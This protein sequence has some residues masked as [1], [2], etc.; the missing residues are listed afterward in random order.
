MMSN[1]SLK[2]LMFFLLIKSPPEGI[3]DVEKE[4]DFC[5][6]LTQIQFRMKRCILFILLVV[7]S[8]SAHAQISIGARV[9]GSMN[10]F[11]FPEMFKEIWT[12]SPKFS[13]LGGLA[14]EIPIG[15]RF[16]LQTEVIYAKRGS[17][18]G[19]F[20]KATEIFDNNEV[21][22][23]WKTDL[24]YLDIPLLF[25]YKFRGRPVGGHLLA[26]LNFGTGLG[27]KEN[28]GLEN[29]DGESFPIEQEI[30]YKDRMDLKQ[31]D[32]VLFGKNSRNDY[33]QGNSGLIFGAGLSLDTEVLK[34]NLD[35]RYF[36][37]TNSIFN[38][39]EDNKYSWADIYDSNAGFDIW[40]RS[41][42]LS[43][44]VFYPLGGGW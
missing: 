14:V 33:L 29:A 24:N 36:I 9:G 8:I 41:L 30:D 12:T 34:Y 11:A 42:Q 23:N 10:R 22:V 20:N 40:N 16:A 13:Y 17:N 32:N 44:T 35:F 19:S 37:G 25:K 7:I 18:F 38:P 1:L 43:I 26:G 4:Y 28:P 27:G 5:L 3:C 15:S 2:I 31:Q 6:L 39:N 21:Y